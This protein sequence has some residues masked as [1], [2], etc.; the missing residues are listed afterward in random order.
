[1]PPLGEASHYT[2]YLATDSRNHARRDGRAYSSRAARGGGL[3]GRVRTRL[4]GLR[5]PPIPV[6]QPPK[7][8]DGL[9]LPHSA[10]N[11]L[12]KRLAVL[13]LRRGQLPQPLMGPRFHEVMD[14]VCQYLPQV[15]LAENEDVVEALSPDG[16]EESL[17]DGVRV[18]RRLR[19][20]GPI[21]Q[22][23]SGSL[24]RST[25]TR[26]ASLASLHGATTGVRTGSTFTT[27]RRS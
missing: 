24:I 19:S 9:D 1:M 20:I 13:H 5:S 6:M 27:M 15:L 16:A 26:D 25:H 10:D 3:P 7:D 2:I 14:V 8:R 11:L 12:G 22:N 4:C 23:V 21:R 18:R 17:A